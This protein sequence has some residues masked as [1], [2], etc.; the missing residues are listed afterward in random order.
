M[1]ERVLYCV[2]CLQEQTTS[3]TNIHQKP[4]SS[5]EVS[6]LEQATMCSD[7]HQEQEKAAVFFA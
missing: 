2:Q 4:L 5:F 7:N 3:L 6:I 1:S